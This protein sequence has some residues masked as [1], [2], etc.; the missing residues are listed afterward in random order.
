MKSQKRGQVWSFDLLAGITLFV[1][2]IIAFFVYSLNQPTQTQDTFELL[3]YEGNIVANNLLSS[4]YPQNWETDS[5]MT[6]GITDNNKI[7]QTKLEQLYE[8]IYTDDNYT[9]TKNLLNTQYDYY[10]FLDQNMTIN[11]D[12]IEGIGKP[13]TTINNVTSRN[14]IKTTRYTIYQNKTTPLYIYTW[15]Q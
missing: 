10:F 11:S 14:L 5:V 13:G 8:I 9:R 7:N 3:Y 1:V 12:S 6:I 2:G 15:E 4:G